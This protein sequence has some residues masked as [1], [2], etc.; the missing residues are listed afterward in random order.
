MR[1]FLIRGSLILL[2]L[3]L[4]AVAT[5][6]W[7][8]RRQVASSLP[9]LDGEC[10]LPGLR[11]QVVVERDGLG[12]PTIRAKNRED[13]AYAVGFL[14]GQE[15][16]FQMDLLRR[17][18]AGELAEMIGPA[19]VDHD[20]EVRIH[21]FREV[22]KGVV[23]AASPEERAIGEVYTRGVNDGLA[24]LGN[25]PFEYLAMGITPK[26]WTSEDTV[27][28][29]F[30]MYLDLQGSDARHEAA[31]SLLAATLPGE[32]ADFLA[33]RGTEWDAPLDGEVF[34]TPPIP[35]PEV[36]DLRQEPI[37][38]EVARVDKPQPALSIFNWN[39]P[40]RHFGAHLGSNNWAVA[41]T[42]T[43]H[44]GAIVADD[45]HLGIAVPNIWYRARFVWPDENGGENNITGVTLPGA[46]A[47]VVGSNGHVAWG[48]TNSE[49]D[50]VDLVVIEPDPNDPDSYLT[51]DGPRKF[52]HHQETI[53]VAGH[54]SETLEIV[55]TIWGPIID[56]DSQGRSRA[57]RWVAH[58]PEGVNLHLMSLERAKTLEEA[59]RIANQ[60]GS[61]AQ[62]FTVAD[63][64]GRIGWTIMGRMP[65]RVGF[66]GR[67]PGS[68]ADG[69]RRW[70]G[71]LEPEEYP[72]VVT[73]PEGRIWTANARVVSGNMYKT[74][75][76]GGYDLGARAKQ[77]RDDLLAIDKASEAD[78]L[79]IQL[80]DRAPFL[81]R[82]QK[83]LL[84][85][86]NSEAVANRPERQEYRDFVEKWGARAAVDSV[87]YRLVRE[88]RIAVTD[89]I[90]EPVTARCRA[91]KPDFKLSRLEFSEGPAWRLVSEKPAHL[92]NP[93]FKSWDEQILSVVD[94]QIDEATADGA[95]LADY[96]W[97]AFNTA[98]IQHPLSRAVPRLS[99]WLDMPAEPLSGSPSDMPRIQTQSAGASQRMA[100]SPGRES[101]GYFHMPCGQSGHPL[102]PHYG[103]GHAAWAHGEKTPF[104]PGK[105]VNTLV[106][107][108]AKS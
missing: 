26:P 40:D 6:A 106:L 67:L 102:S 76:D 30:S 43:K 77:I 89:E 63:K 74:L 95:K 108:P 19:L 79:K 53:A 47:I 73:P 69:A 64:D 49:G 29:S 24:A 91:V 36:F 10:L 70:D 34:A 98:K 59:M 21:R 35:G 3:L 85:T 81:E 12:V 27:L 71:W 31:H 86:L 52:E 7:W 8:M 38:K 18:S 50:W 56:K 46:P 88:F 93:K 100:V 94:Q 5:G 105:T 57:Q 1:K 78:M 97:G 62:N 22:S 45:M 65:R 87:G 41:G 55:S 72:K 54:P 4:A 28:V 75:G 23:E 107:R 44:G 20:R 83:L 51:P 104:L 39:D 37:V 90:F 66:D 82:W 58:D 14:H 92:L 33:P 32:M 42:H 13:L 16:Y 11:E 17:N 99:R 48:F 80:D 101:E 2:V 84:N 9:Q 103:D 60:C 15:R 61:P 25:L 68:W 96:T